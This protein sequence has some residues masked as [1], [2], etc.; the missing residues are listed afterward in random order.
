MFLKIFNIKIVFV[1]S[2]KERRRNLA[3]EKFVK[4]YLLAKWMFFDLF[5]AL[6]KTYSF[7]LILFKHSKY[8]ISSFV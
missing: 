1:Y 5:E 2:R 6:I 8:Q 3:F 4:V 7:L